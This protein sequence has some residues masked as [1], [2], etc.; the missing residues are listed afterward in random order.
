V[1]LLNLLCSC[2]FTRSLIGQAIASQRPRENCLLSMTPKPNHSIRAEFNAHCVVQ[3]WHSKGKA[4]TISQTGMNTKRN[5][6]SEL[7]PAFIVYCLLIM[8]LGIFAQSTEWKYQFCYFPPVF[9]FPSFAC[10]HRK[11]P[12]RSRISSLG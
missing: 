10:F 7:S 3:M 6:P 11:H 4:I 5:A 8:I 9:A 12:H 1:R 2:S